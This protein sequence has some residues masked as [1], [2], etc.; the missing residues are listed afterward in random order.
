MS[1]HLVGGGPF[2]ASDAAAPFLAEATARSAAVGRTVPRI[3]LLSVCRADGTSPSSTADI[4]EVLGG[5]RAAEV[6]TTEVASGQAFDTTVLSDVDALVVAG[7]LTP[8]YLAAVAPLVDQVRL[9]V[10]DGLPYLGYS[11]GAMIAAD[12]ALVGGWR[13]GGVEVCPEGASE[14]LDEVELREGLGLVDLTID[15]HAVQA[16]T[17]ARLVAS[18]EAEFVTAGLAIDEDTA[19]VVGEGALE[20]RGTGSVWRVVAGDESVAVATMGA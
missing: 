2:A 15:V 12:R 9:L 8:D 17:L 3:A 6:V 4:A 14:G 11:A 20:V 13:I 7:G 1:I 5:A 18:A 10:A 19:L 16:G